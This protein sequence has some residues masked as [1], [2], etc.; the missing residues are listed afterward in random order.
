[1]LS[2]MKKSWNIKKFFQNFPLEIGETQSQPPQSPLLSNR[3]Q[4]SCGR[5]RHLSLGILS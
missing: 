4:I 3:P 1:M 5:V 2:S